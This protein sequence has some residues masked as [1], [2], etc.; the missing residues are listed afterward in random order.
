LDQLFGLM[1]AL[2]EIR[3]YRKSTDLLIP[4][5]PFA[6]V[7]KEVLANITQEDFRIQASALGALQEATEAALVI[8]FQC[9][10]LVLNFITANR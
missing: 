3:Y 8:Q 6:R 4:K 7:V 10:K 9:I 2:R 5:V 1:R